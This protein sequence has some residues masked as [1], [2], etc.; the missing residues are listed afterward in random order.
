MNQFKNILGVYPKGW[1]LPLVYRR[2]G[3]KHEILV[4][5][6]GLH[7]ET[8]L[9]PRRRPQRPRPRPERPPD[10]QPD[11][12]KDKQPSRRRPVPSPP[13]PQSKTP[14]KLKHLYVKKDGYANYYFNQLEQKRV[15]AAVKRLGDFSKLG[16]T[17]VIV[18]KNQKGDD[19]EFTLAN[20]GLGLVL[21]ERAYFQ[22]LDG[23]DLQDEPI[24][25]GG[26]LV[27]MQHLK[28]ML[29]KGESG[30]TDWY[31]LGSEPLDGRGEKVDV[32]VS[33][34]TG[35]ESRWYFSRKTREF[36]G[37]D[38]RLEEGVD[39]CQIRFHGF[40]TF[41]GRKLPESFSV[42]RAIQ[43]W[44]TFMIERFDMADEPINAAK[45]PEK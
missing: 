43:L 42:Q 30:F 40:Q 12:K 2:E 35:V 33:E 37:F 17:W 15:L 25:T 29:T 39:E 18:G 38:T 36:I 34:L 11:E 23:S 45:Q 5:L 7:R 32:L 14:E 8:E 10:R 22:P 21:A 3:H 28:L 1:K 16:G 4:R 41:K 24:G 20:Q 26:L 44:D 27:A 9:M 6:Q 31:Y 13:Q 19:F